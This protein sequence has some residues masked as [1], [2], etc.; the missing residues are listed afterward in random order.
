MDWLKVMSQRR[1]QSHDQ[2]WAIISPVELC[3]SRFWLFSECFPVTPISLA[4]RPAGEQKLYINLCHW[5]NKTI[6]KK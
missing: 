6:G 5:Q 2:F 4:H 3:I 1:H